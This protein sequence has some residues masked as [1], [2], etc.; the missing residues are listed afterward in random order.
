M[1]ID[2]EKYKLSPNNYL[3]VESIK[4]QII[5]GH[6]S[7]HDMKHFNGWV[8]R[9]N[10]K[11]LKTAAFTIDT[12]GL[13][14]KHFNPKFQSKY[15][16]EPEQDSKSIVILLENDGWLSR[17]LTNDEFYN[18]KGDIYKGRVVGK[19]W[20]GYNKWAHY[21]DKQ[22]DSCVELVSMLCEEF[23]IPN[24]ALSHNTKIDD[25]TEFKGVVYKS[26][27]EKHYT[28]IS[29]AWDCEA[30]KNKLEIKQKL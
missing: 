27:L 7:N 23:F 10:G 28:D 25:L 11:Y 22:L 6:T 21:T 30:F 29:P 4:K 12:E 15:F 20:R 14:H 3:K 26:N 13:I 5:I 17:K 9:H 16:G 18:W 8:N 2:D 19:I 1:V 24:V